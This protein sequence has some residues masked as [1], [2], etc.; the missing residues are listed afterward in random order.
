MLQSPTAGPA[1]SLIANSYN[2]GVI[3]SAANAAGGIVAMINAYSEVK[4]CINS[5]TVTTAVKYAGGIVGQNTSKDKPG[6]ITRSYYLENTVT[7][8]TDLNS[9][10]NALTET[11]MYG[12]AI[13]TEMSGFA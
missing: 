11:E 12:S 2:T 5:A 1:P 7:A 6:I 10:G 8:A 9:E 13:A 4:N 3:T